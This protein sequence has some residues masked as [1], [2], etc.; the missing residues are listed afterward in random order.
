MD[1]KLYHGSLGAGLIEV[2]NDANHDPNYFGAQNGQ[3]KA[4][5]MT[6]KDDTFL[7]QAEIVNYNPTNR[8]IYLAMELEYMEQQP[9]DWMD[10]STIV[11][12]ATGCGNPLY[13]PPPGAT[14]YNH[15]SAPFIIK[16]DGYIVNARK[17]KP[18]F[19]RST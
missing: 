5:F 9:K 11:V 4:A 16:H 6:G 3:A 8:S 2:G 12:S 18:A 17:Y 13:K 10:S 15:T 14:K 1:D 19:C 7:L